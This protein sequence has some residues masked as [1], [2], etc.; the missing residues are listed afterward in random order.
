MIKEPFYK[1]PAGICSSC[2]HKYSDDSIWYDLKHFGEDH[3]IT[4]NA[5]IHLTGCKHCSLQFPPVKKTADELANMLVIG[6]KMQPE[7]AFFWVLAYYMGGDLY[8]NGN[9]VHLP[10]E[11]DIIKKIEKRILKKDL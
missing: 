1:P 8:E 9:I 7:H 3:A 10:K 2:G 6:D 11:E 5:F 4:Y